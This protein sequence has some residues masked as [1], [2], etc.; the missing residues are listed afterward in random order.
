MTDK[1]NESGQPQEQPKPQQPSEIQP[2]PALEQ[3]IER[4]LNPSKETRQK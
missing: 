3:I 4:G 1:D 2:D